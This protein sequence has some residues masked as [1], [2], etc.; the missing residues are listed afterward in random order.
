M[1]SLARVSDPT[2][3]R[4]KR[5]PA[6]LS[7]RSKKIDDYTVEIEVTENLSAACSTTSPTS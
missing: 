2:P 3:H 6:G 5:Q 4:C 1:A 7:R